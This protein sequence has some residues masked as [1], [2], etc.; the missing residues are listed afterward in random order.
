MRG[1]GRGNPK[2]E[3]RVL[4]LASTVFLGRR[5]LVGA[6]TRGGGRL[7]GVLHTECSGT[8]VTDDAARMLSPSRHREQV[9]VIIAD[10]TKLDGATL[11]PVR[12]HQEVGKPVVLLNPPGPAVRLGAEPFAVPTEVSG[13]SAAAAGRVLRAAGGGAPEAVRVAWL[14][15][16]AYASAAIHKV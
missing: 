15:V 8:D 2:G 7:E 1:T 9:R 5:V 14:A 13:L 3:I 6:V 16:G 11:D 10:S 12:L 4:G